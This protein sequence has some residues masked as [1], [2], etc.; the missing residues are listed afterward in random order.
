[1]VNSWRVAADSDLCRD[2]QA[3]A[4]ACTLYHDGACGLYGARLAIDKD[5]TRCVFNVRIC[6]HC[7]TPDCVA[8]C[9]VEAIELDQSG[10]AHLNQDLCIRCGACQESCPFDAIMFDPAR[11]RYLKCDLCAGRDQGPV[12][13]AVCPT[14]A[15]VLVPAAPGQGGTK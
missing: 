4:L 14:G 8:A 3:C 11:E 1:M 6:Q 5:M 10:V 15:L 13:V 2:C 9:P 7:A 12:C